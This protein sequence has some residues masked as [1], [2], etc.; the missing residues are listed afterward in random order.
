MCGGRG[1]AAGAHT[2]HDVAIGHFV[3]P[4]VI[5]VEHVAGDDTALMDG[6]RIRI[7]LGHVVDDVDDDLAGD[8]VAQLILRLVG[9]GLGQV[10]GP[11]LAPPGVF[12]AEVRV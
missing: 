7:G 2:D 6:C 9:E 5:V 1:V 10:F 3:R 4:H 8:G 11:S 12:G